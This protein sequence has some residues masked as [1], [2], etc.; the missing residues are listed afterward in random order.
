MCVPD[1]GCTSSQKV[2]QENFPRTRKD[3][4][5]ADAE[6]AYL[7]VPEPKKEKSF[8]RWAAL[9]LP[10]N[11]CRPWTSSRVDLRG[12]NDE[13]RPYLCDHHVCNSCLDAGARV[14]TRTRSRFPH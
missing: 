12:S 9:L 10:C 2:P 4:S 3:R 7:A 8:I 5:V 13:A 11:F 14:E 6:Y 1:V